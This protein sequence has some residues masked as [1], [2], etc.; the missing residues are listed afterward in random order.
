MIDL[1]ISKEGGK[2]ERY[3]VSCRELISEIHVL[4]C[5]A[6]RNVCK[7]KLFI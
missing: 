4:V 1:T 7:A 6:A 5:F 3:L 2:R